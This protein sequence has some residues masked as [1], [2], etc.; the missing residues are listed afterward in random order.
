MWSTPCTGGF[1]YTP[2]CTLSTSGCFP[3]GTMK[4]QIGTLYFLHVWDTS[5]SCTLDL[6]KYPTTKAVLIVQ[7]SYL[8]LCTRL[9]GYHSACFFL[10]MS[11]CCLP[12]NSL[13]FVY[14]FCGENRH[15]SRA[16]HPKSGG[17]HLPLVCGPAPHGH[18]YPVHLGRSPKL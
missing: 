14:G 7:F 1:L 12:K 3:C 5:Q 16:G 13:R 15:L 8:G 18:R 9:L 6:Q 17:M 10:P 2:R 11:L 4:L